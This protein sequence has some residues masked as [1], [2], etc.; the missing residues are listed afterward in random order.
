MKN[1]CLVFLISC[2]SS[3]LFAASFFNP[4]QQLRDAIEQEVS[5]V[6]VGRELLLKTE[7]IRQGKKFRF[8]C[9]DFSCRQEFVYDHDDVLKSINAH[10]YRATTAYLGW[11]VF[12]AIYRSWLNYQ[13]QELYQ[14]DAPATLERELLIAYKSG[15]FIHQRNQILSY[16]RSDDFYFSDNHDYARTRGYGLIYL[17]RAFIE[18]A[19]GL[20]SIVREREASTGQ[21]FPTTEVFIESTDDEALIAAALKVYDM[22]DFVIHYH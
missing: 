14:V 13:L 15:Q 3:S 10:F 11:I 20:K 22:L 19:E 17:K 12:E 18:G 5:T 2:A 21:Q 8:Y 1:F 4:D 16:Q 7:S 6:E 9:M